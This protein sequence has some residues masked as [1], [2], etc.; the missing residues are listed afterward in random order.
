M[1]S[2]LQSDY[3]WFLKANLARYKGKYVAIAGRKVVAAGNNAKAVYSEAIKKLPKGAKPQ[4]A[5]I[6]QENVLVLLS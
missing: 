2:T 1:N 6:P 5:K 3:E 4:I